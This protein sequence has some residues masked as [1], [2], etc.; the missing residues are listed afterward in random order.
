MTNPIEW[1]EW[2]YEKWFVGHPWRGFLAVWVLLCMVAFVVLTL[3]W[4]RAVDRYKEKVQQLPKPQTVTASNSASRTA[5]VQSGTSQ[6]MPQGATTAPPPAPPKKAMRPQKPIIKPARQQPAQSQQYC[7]LKGTITFCNSPGSEASNDKIRTDNPIAVEAENSDHTRVTG[8]DYKKYEPAVNIDTPPAPQNDSGQ[9]PSSG[10]RATISGNT[11]YGCNPA[12]VTTYGV[13][14][15]V[16][17]DDDH[18][19]PADAC[20]FYGGVGHMQGAC[21]GRSHPAAAVHLPDKTLRAQLVKW[22]RGVANFWKNDNLKKWNDRFGHYDPSKMS[23]DQLCADIDDHSGKMR[24]FRL[25]YFGF[26]EYP[27]PTH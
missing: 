21:F 24:F 10:G 27:I 20:K 6:G 4:L 25:V 15:V 11:T 14:T 3:P 8:L 19:M 2:V 12:V 26:E 23:L 1:L 9:S 13:P 22:Q 5:T 7:D 17:N 18:I 16:S